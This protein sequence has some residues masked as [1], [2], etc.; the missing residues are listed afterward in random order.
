MATSWADLARRAAGSVSPGAGAERQHASVA[1]VA[2]DGS[3]GVVH[4]IVDGGLSAEAAQAFAQRFQAA[5][6]EEGRHMRVVAVSRGPSAPLDV[7]WTP[8]ARGVSLAAAAHEGEGSQVRRLHVSRSIRAAQKLS[9]DSVLDIGQKMRG[10]FEL[11]RE[12]AGSLDGLVAQYSAPTTGHET[13]ASTI[14]SLGARVD[15][16]NNE[17]VERVSRQARALAKARQ[18]AQ[19][20][21]RLGQNISDIASSA[22]M[23]TFNARIESARIGEAGKGFAV[24]AQSIQDLATQ[25]R[26]TNTSVGVLAGNLATSLPE[27]GTEAQAMS[28]D[29]RAQLAAL[30][31]QLG[32]VREQLEA[33]RAEA[34]A[35][36]ISSTEN[37]TQLKASADG[38]IEKLQFQDRSRQMLD[39]AR[40]QAEALLTLL[41]VDESQVAQ[42]MVDQVG[43]LG[44]QLEENTALKQAGSVELF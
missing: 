26:E 37:A 25:I 6:T 40:L 9:E 11:A 21:M 39:E 12:H 18:W 34:H 20:I 14:D 38:V 8:V 7:S 30:T 24:I 22:R 44:K 31:E 42:A 4:V 19:D 15:Q 23:L 43:W 41:G 32:K 33:T 2:I 13:I 1:F 17:L 10:I 35:T 27:L 16:V 5:C 3:K 36:L 29:A 28:T